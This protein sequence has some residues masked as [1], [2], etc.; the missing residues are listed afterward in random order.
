MGRKNQDNYGEN[1][2]CDGS[3]DKVPGL[4]DP[5]HAGAQFDLHNT[6]QHHAKDDRHSRQRQPFEDKAKDAK[7]R[8]DQAIRG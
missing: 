7:A 4:F 8:S 2:E 1:D 6:A 5:R 3:V